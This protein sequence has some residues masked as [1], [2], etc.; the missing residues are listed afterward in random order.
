VIHPE[1]AEVKPRGQR[2]TFWRV[3]VSDPGGQPTSE[4]IRA[5]RVSA[6]SAGWE[7]KLP[8]DTV[9]VLQRVEGDSYAIPRISPRNQ[10]LQAEDVL[11]D[12]PRW[13]TLY[14][15]SR[16]S[17]LSYRR[18]DG[19]VYHVWHP[20]GGSRAFIQLFAQGVYS[21]RVREL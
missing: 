17:I 10:P 20:R 19:S 16:R 4:R 1:Q 12:D 2:D 14:Q 18:P 15:R 7:L 9:I 21:E 8:G 11:L 5:A 6:T 13:E 3:P